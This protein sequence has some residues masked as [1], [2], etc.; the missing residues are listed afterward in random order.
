M[1]AFRANQL[2][3]DLPRE[4][5][6]DLIWDYDFAVDNAEDAIGELLGNWQLLKEV[7][8]RSFRACRLA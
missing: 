7:A 8:E 4:E 2:Q 6:E 3:E 1:I 5:A